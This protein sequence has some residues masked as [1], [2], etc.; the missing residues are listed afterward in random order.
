MRTSYH[1]ETGQLIY[2]TIKLIGFYIVRGLYNILD[3]DFGPRFSP[4]RNTLSKPGDK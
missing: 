4:F 3:A 1:V 2:L